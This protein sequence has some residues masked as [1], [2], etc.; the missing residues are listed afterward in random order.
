MQ[1]KYHIYNRM[2]HDLAWKY[3]RLYNV[4][5]DDLYQEGFF[6]FLQAMKTWNSHKSNFSTWLFII[7]KQGMHK[8][9][10]NWNN[11][12]REIPLKQE[13]QDVIDEITESEKIDK[14]SPVAKKIIQILIYWDIPNRKRISS[15]KQMLKQ[16]GFTKKQIREGCKELKNFLNN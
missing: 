10:K 3:S 12:F 8:Y 1:T 5:R 9:C 7:A 16:N 11:F 14:L 4:P 2:I 15:F 13:H 6:F